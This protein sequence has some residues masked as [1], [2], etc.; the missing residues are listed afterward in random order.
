MATK[1]NIRREDLKSY[2]RMSK[3]RYKKVLK[4]QTDYNRDH[5]KVMAIKFS[6][7]K[8]KDILEWMD[9]QDNITE[10]TRRAIRREIEREKTEA[11]SAK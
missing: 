8:D 11:E 2:N 10:A 5:Y 1:Y 4:Y 3:E 7:S 9:R 6:Y